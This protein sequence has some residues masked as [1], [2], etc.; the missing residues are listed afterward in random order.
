[1]Y[2]CRIKSN[3]FSAMANK[4]DIFCGSVRIK[5][6]ATGNYNFKKKNKLEK[7]QSLVAADPNF[8]LK[9]NTKDRR[10]NKLKIY[11]QERSDKTQEYGVIAATKRR[12]V[13]AKEINAN[14]LLRNEASALNIQ[15]RVS[16]IIHIASHS[17][18]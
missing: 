3:T 5:T 6:I 9:T 18:S 14:L 13:I 16:K 12:S 7:N 10:F 17:F 4:K 11:N 15:K 1:M 8:D 2:E